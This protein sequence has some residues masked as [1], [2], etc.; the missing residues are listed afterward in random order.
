MKVVPPILLL[1]AT[2][3]STLGQGQLILSAGD[4]YTLEFSDLALEG[5]WPLDDPRPT[6]FGQV[7]VAHYGFEAGDSLLIEMFED[8]TAEPPVGTGGW[9]WPEGTVQSPPPPLFIESFGAWQDLQGV[10]RLTMLS[11]SVTI[12]DVTAFAVRDEVDGRFRYL[13]AI[14]LPEPSGAMLAFV[15]IGAL[16]LRLRLRS[17]LH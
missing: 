11:G 2:C 4:S 14:P 10:I 9:D 7:G 17:S 15:G 12:V 16:F 6:P 3:L 13:S 1:C 8:T 5:P